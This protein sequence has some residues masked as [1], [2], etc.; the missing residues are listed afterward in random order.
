MRQTNSG[1]QGFT[2]KAAADDP[3]YKRSVAEPVMIAV[4]SMPKEYRQCVHDFG[5]VD[6][7]RAWRRGLSPLEIRAKAESNGGVFTL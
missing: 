1:A 3:A 2:A 4:D 5:Y 6:V 7:Y